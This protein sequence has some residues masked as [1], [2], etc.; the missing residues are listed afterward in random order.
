MKKLVLVSAVA[1]ALAI[2]ALVQAAD[3]SAHTV[4]ANVGVFSNYVF[5]GVTQTSEEMALQGGIDYSHASG[6]YA[7]TWGSNISW[8]SDTAAANGYTG[9]SL[10]LDLYGGY[11]GSFAKDFGYDVGAIYYY[12]P[13]EQARGFVSP[14]TTEVY[15]AL[16]WKWLSAKLSYAVSEYF[17]FQDT[18]G[19]YYFD[20]SANVPV[21][22][23]G[24]T[25]MAH[26]GYLGVEG[27]TAAACILPTSVGPTCSNNDAWGYTD[28]KVGLSYALPKGLTVGAFYTDTG[29]EEVAYTVAGRDWAD[30][31]AAVYLQ[32]TF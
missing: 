20:V 4:S 3:E 9:S 23:T 30:K 15:G 29:A 1:S 25:V 13:G 24:L 32:K 6:F 14:N 26:V 31:Q 18:E 21:A 27:D 10:E 16:S 17:G 5:R 22:D 7:G 11:K 19:T 2:P 8:L 28:W 12:Y